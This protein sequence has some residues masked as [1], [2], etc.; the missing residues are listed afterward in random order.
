MKDSRDYREVF[1]VFKKGS[2]MENA[3]FF[4]KLGY[5]FKNVY[6][7]HFKYATLGVILAAIFAV[8]FASDVFFREY[9]DLDFIL[10]GSV[11]ADSEEMQKLADDISAFVVPENPEAPAKIGRQM[12]STKS[13]VGTGDQALAFDGITSANIDKISVSM[14]DDEILLFFFDKRYAEWY[15]E[16]GAFEPLSSFGIES[17]NEFFVRVDTL[18][19][20]K[21]YDI[22]HDNGIYAGIKIKTEQRLKK[23]RIVRKYENA[24]NVIRGMLAAN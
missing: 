17:E 13:T 4:E 22:A 12:L 2:F 15:A 14:A 21:D 3:S 20:W 24:A 8:T 23:E 7:F 1:A 10:A 5:W 11:F 19:F 9:N 18:P 6:W 16:Q